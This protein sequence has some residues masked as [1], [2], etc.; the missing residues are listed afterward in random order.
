MKLPTVKQIE[1]LLETEAGASC[2]DSWEDRNHV[3]I[4]IKNLLY[5]VRDNRIKK[6][7]D[8]NIHFT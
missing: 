1:R 2:M 4:V 7:E 3:A 5:A 8:I 6:G